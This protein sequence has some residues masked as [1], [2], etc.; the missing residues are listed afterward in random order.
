M[1]LGPGG[2]SRNRLA[3][4]PGSAL[5]LRK[6]G[7]RNLEEFEL[8]IPVADDGLDIDAKPDVAVANEES[9]G[10]RGNSDVERC[11]DTVA[12]I[13]FDGDEID[14][15]GPDV[16]GQGCLDVEVGPIYVNGKLERRRVRY[17]I[18]AMIETRRTLRGPK[19]Q[20]KP[21]KVSAPE[22]AAAGRG[23]R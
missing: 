4:A 17:N 12:E 15:E 22:P 21:A 10:A 14:V 8:F 3:L 11:R 2:G 16:D 1:K 23:K 5:D 18:K 6:S 20:S 9:D 7:E 13:A 19:D